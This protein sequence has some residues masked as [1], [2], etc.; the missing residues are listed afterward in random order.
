[1][2]GLLAVIDHSKTAWC[3]CLAD[4]DECANNVSCQV[5]SKEPDALRKWAVD[6]VLDLDQRIR[7][8]TGTSNPT[9][10]LAEQYSLCSRLQAENEGLR[11][12]MNDAVQE[13]EVHIGPVKQLVV[14]HVRLNV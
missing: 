5:S 9:L 1:M 10:D 14:Y 12:C 3:K 2:I 8:S 11:E 6:S 13:N 4:G 7:G